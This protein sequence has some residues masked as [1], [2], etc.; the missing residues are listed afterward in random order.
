MEFLLLVAMLVVVLIYALRH[1]RGVKVALKT[2]LVEFSLDAEGVVPLSVKSPTIRQRPAR[3]RPLSEKPRTRPR[4]RV[5]ER[6]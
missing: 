1:K 2:P 6:P 3:K 4:G 5:S